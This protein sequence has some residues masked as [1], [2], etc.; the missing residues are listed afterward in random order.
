MIHSL[1]SSLFLHPDTPHSSIDWGTRPLTCW[2]I[3][4][5]CREGDAKPLTAIG[6]ARPHGVFDG[7][8]A[9]SIVNALISEIKGLSWAIP[10]VPK[11]GTNTNIVLKVLD[12]QKRTEASQPVEFGGYTDLRTVGTM[13]LVFSQLRKRIFHDVQNNLVILKKDI[14]D[15]LVADVRKALSREGKS[16]PRVSTGDIL[17]AWLWKAVY[18]HSADLELR[19]HC[20]NLAS[21]RGLLS[22]YDP[23]IQNYPHNAFV[24]L[25]YP[26]FSIADLKLLPLH[27]LSYRLASAR[28][29]LSIS[30]VHSA[31]QTLKT[32]TFAAPF[33]PKSDETFFISNVSASR[34]LE[35]DWTCIGAKCTLC[36]F[37]YALTALGS[38]LTNAA[39]ISGRL[40]D[41]SVLLDVILMRSRVEALTAEVDR[42]EALVAPKA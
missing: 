3:T 24:P 25:P 12:D 21:F 31:E 14:V 42:L 30:H 27:D 41:S 20:S 36:G 40:P 33:H 18:A 23:E 7:T 9:M 1:P 32:A 22:K 37:R 38:P 28:V 13:K 29:S 6:F 5:L 11:P 15:F 19:V 35:A 4:R 26:R 10:P 34:I 17:V 16:S 8:G 2:H 39:Y